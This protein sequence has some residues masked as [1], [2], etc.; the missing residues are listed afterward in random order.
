MPERRRG[1]FAK[2]LYQIRYRGF[3]SLSLRKDT[4]SEVCTRRKD[5]LPLLK[6]K[7]LVTL[8]YV[9]DFRENWP[10]TREWLIFAR[11]RVLAAAIYLRDIRRHWPEIRVV[12]EHYRNEIYLPMYN[13]YFAAMAYLPFIGWLVPLYLK[14]DDELCQENGRRGFVLSVVFTGTA[15]ALFFLYFILS[16]GTGARCASCWRLRYTSSIPRTFQS[17]CG[18]FITWSGKKGLKCPGWRNIF[19]WWSCSGTIN[20]RVYSSAG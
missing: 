4:R 1:R 10:R 15:L 17:A 7:A 5:R 12:L 9:R 14:P 8:R 20:K 2:P 19:T 18:R 6:E 16:R 3:E 11:G 13:K